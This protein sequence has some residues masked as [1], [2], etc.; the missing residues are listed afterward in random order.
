LSWPVFRPV[1]PIQLQHPHSRVSIFPALRSLAT[2]AF[3]SAGLVCNVRQSVSGSSYE[4]PATSYQSLPLNKLPLYFPQFCSTR[5]ELVNN[6]HLHSPK[7]TVIRTRLSAWTCQPF[8]C[9]RTFIPSP[10][11]CPGRPYLRPRLL[12]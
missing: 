3:D 1:P 8:C 5:A 9:Q 4:S 6:P 12:R 7:R 2:Q 11:E 10:S